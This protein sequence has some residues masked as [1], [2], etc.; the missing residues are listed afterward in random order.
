MTLLFFGDAGRQLF[1][2]YHPPAGQVAVR[3]AAVL[4]APWGP[5]YFVSHRTFRRLAI[6]L[7]EVG[8]HVLRFDYYGTGDSAGERDEGDL[9]SWQADAALAVEELKDISQESRIALFGVRLGAVVAWRLA[10]EREDVRSVV[11]WDPVFSGSGYLKELAATQSEVDRW[12]LSPP[13]RGSGRVSEELLGTP[14]SPAMR[15]SIQS[16]TPDEFRGTTAARVSIFFSDEQQ[17]TELH[18]ALRAAGTPFHTETMFGQ[19]PWRED[20]L[21]HGQVPSAVIERMVEVVP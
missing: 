6:R 18:H 17:G 5:E 15:N 1:G 4:C 9:A 11:M 7:S 19:T 13:R 20:T 2:A 16:V 14:L 10:R 8:Y 12:S 3:G 21:L